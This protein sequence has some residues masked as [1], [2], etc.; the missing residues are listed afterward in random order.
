[1]FDNIFPGF[2]VLAHLDLPDIELHLYGHPYG[3]IGIVYRNNSGKLINDYGLSMNRRVQCI[4]IEI[5]NKHVLLF[6][7]YFPCKNDPNYAADVEIICAFISSVKDM[8]DIEQFDIVIAGD[9]N[10]DVKNGTGN[11]DLQVFYELLRD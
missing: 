3:G 6:N 9:F 10:F 1:M 5:C 7:L 8:V 4:L 11:P 2:T